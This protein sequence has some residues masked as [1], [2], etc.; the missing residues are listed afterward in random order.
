[1]EQICTLLPSITRAIKNPCWTR[2]VPFLS[3]QL[4]SDCRGDC[5]IEQTPTQLAVARPFLSG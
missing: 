5:P 2:S 3:R 1:M 4:G